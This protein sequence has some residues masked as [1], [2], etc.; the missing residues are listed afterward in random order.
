MEDA[1][2]LVFC[3]ANFTTPIL[4]RKEEVSRYQEEDRSKKKERKV[5]MSGR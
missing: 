2:W 1:N 3:M 4:G 5:G